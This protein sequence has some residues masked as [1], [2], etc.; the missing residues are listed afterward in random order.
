MTIT[1]IVDVSA[2]SCLCSDPLKGIYIEKRT[3]SIVSN[4]I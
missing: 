4:K 3:G 1:F 2:Q